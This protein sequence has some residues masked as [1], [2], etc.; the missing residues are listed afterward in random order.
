MSY[1][2]IYESSVDGNRNELKKLVVNENI[3]KNKEIH[4]ILQKYVKHKVWN[5]NNEE[6]SR[7]CFS[8]FPH[9]ETW[10]SP[11]NDF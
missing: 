8:G 7:N 10:C 6:M 3:M 11:H 5:V 2:E 9:T 1:S 4:D